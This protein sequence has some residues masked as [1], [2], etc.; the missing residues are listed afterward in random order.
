MPWFLDPFFLVSRDFSDP[1]LW[2]FRFDMKTTYSISLEKLQ[3]RE[4]V[5]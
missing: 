2:W 5:R 4:K 3:I 1:T